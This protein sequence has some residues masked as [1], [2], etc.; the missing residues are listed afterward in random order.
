MRKISLLISSLML[1]SCTHSE[2]TTHSDLSIP[3]EWAVSNNKYLDT[4][5]NLVCLPWWQQFNDP[6]LNN[7]I[8]EGL[9]Y[10]NDINIAMANIE[11]AQGE[12]KRVQLNWIPEVGAVGGYSSFPDLGYPGVLLAIVPSYTLNIFQQIKEQKKANYE[13]KAT[14]AIHDAVRLAIIG[15]IASSYFSYVAQLEQLE[16]LTSLENDLA[17]V[18]SVS[19]S[20][21]RGDLYSKVEVQQAETALNLIQARKKVVEH[22][23]VVSQNSIKYLLNKNPGHLSE[24]NQ[25]SQ[26]SGQQLIIGALPLNIIE[27]RPDMQQAKYEL[28]ASNEGIGLAFSNYLP[29][30]QLSMARGEIATVPN[31]YHLGTNIYFDQ[32]LL[33]VPI[34]EASVYG[35]IQK[36]K[37][38]N[39]ASYYRYTDTLRKVLRDVS[40]ALSAHDLYTKRLDDTLKAENSFREVHQL[41]D[42]LYQ[43]GI[44][45]NLELI[46]TRIQLTHVALMANQ[47]KLEQFITIVNLYQDL[48]AGYN[49][50]GEITE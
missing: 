11:A 43:R 20:M 50:R 38:L 35:Q 3:Q 29:T 5:V 4:D 37:G 8:D 40:N 48:A 26:L 6:I 19:E 10:N 47:H 36:A 45:S 17:K 27:N 34:L 2:Y 31:G 1:I 21:H 14:A 30:V 15:Q 44:I 28:E 41:N 12:L 42:D 22:N 23:I 13:L 33:E 25:F 9:R 16:L 7:L 18:A 39:K 46:D 32:A 24:A 49:Y